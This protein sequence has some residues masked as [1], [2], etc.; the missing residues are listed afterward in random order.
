MRFIGC[1][2][3]LLDNIKNVIHENVACAQTFCD[4]FAGTGAVSRYF[5]SW[6]EVSSNDLLYF[7][8]VLQRATVENDTKP[9]FKG[10]KNVIGDISPILYLNSLAESPADIEQDQCFFFNT[11]SPAGNRMYLTEENAMRI[12]WA[13]IFIEKWR[14]QQL[15]NDNEYFYL[16]ACLVEGIPFVS[17]IAGTYGAFLKSWDKRAYKKFELYE[18]EVV[19]NGRNNRAFNLDG[20]DLVRQLK[21]DIL[22]IDPPYNERQY[23]PNYHLLETAARY[24]YPQVKGVTGLRPCASGKSNYCNKKIVCDV[25]YDLVSNAD[26][27]H[28][29]LSYNTEGLM[30][31]D[32]IERILK[33]VGN[34][35][36]YKVYTIDYR[37]FKSRK[38]S[39]NGQIKEMLFYIRK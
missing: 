21:G 39:F 36:T 12:D 7:S 5:K 30:P 34:P 4:I 8:Y 20:N 29:I 15:I 18:L 28:I 14:S 3:L 10:L 17:N 13:R 22:Y 6:F 2:T 38:T 32:D 23:L 27:K 1:K 37:R 35:A 16:I 11:Y 33:T 25:F 31:V 24:D 9:L 26:F 19:S